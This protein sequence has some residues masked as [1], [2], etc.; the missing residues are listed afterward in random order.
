MQE[1]EQ[2]LGLAFSSSSFRMKDEADLPQPMC[3][4]PIALQKGSTLY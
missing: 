2:G 1:G 3:I 4:L